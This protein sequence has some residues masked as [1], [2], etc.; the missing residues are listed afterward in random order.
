MIVVT[1]TQRSGT[2]STMALEH[3]ASVDAR[4]LA[5]ILGRR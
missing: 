4:A 2:T 5:D 1:G 3:Q